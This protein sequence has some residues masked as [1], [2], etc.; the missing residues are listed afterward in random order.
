MGKGTLGVCTA[1]NEYTALVL[2]STEQTV[3]YQ[4]C[5]RQTVEWP[6]SSGHTLYGPHTL[7][8]PYTVCYWC[9]KVVWPLSIFCVPLCPENA[10]QSA[11]LG[12]VVSIHSTYAP[13]HMPAVLLNCTGLY[14]S[15][16]LVHY[17]LCWGCLPSKHNLHC[18]SMLTSITCT[19]LCA[20]SG[21]S[22]LVWCLSVWQ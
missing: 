13:A 19:H 16:I 14:C 1:L 11:P 21:D 15:C 6:L 7:W 22:V 9:G 4:L 18:T 3:V 2:I 10:S 5:T 12:A 8:A 17:L 20:G